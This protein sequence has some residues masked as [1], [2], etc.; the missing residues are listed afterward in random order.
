MTE[1]DIEKHGDWGGRRQTE[2]SSEPQDRQRD[3]IVDGMQETEMQT[4]R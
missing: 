1:R 3:G 4:R 2:L